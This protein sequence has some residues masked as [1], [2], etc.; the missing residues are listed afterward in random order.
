MA[1][2]IFESLIKNTHL[3]EI[4]VNSAGTA[5]MSHHAI[6]ADLKEVMDQNKIKYTGHL[7]Q[8][9]DKNIMEKS[10]LILVMTRSHKEEVSWRFPQFKNKVL[11][12]SE[13][14]DN[15]QRD[16]I[17]PIGQGKDA[18]RKAFGDIKDYLIKLVEKLSNEPEKKG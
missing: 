5:A 8:R 2:K 3:K 14:S 13:Y 4:E 12:L 16:I 18:Y 6:M 10:D 1:E 15:E 17:D 9:L 11:L 7:P